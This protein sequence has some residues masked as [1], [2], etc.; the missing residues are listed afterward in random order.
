MECFFL[1]R[2]IQKEKL[3]VVQSAVAQFEISEDKVPQA[4][5]CGQQ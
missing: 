4:N 5:L 1:L 2:L 3:E